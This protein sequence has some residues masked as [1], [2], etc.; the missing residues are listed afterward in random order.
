MAARTTGHRPLSP[1]IAALRERALSLQDSY[2]PG[3]RFR[4][5]TQF[6]QHEHDAADPPA[7]RQAKCFAYVLSS[8]DIAIHSLER[9]VGPQNRYIS[10]HMGVSEDRKLRWAQLLDAPEHFA[11]GVLPDGAPAELAPYCEFWRGKPTLWARAQDIWRRTS[12]DMTDYSPLFRASVTTRAH[13]ML[14]YREALDR[15]LNDIIDECD[16][17]LCCECQPGKRSFLGA[18]K[19][20]L[21]AGIQYS[22]RYANLA[23][24]MAANEADPE[25][26][27][28]LEAISANCGTCLEH[29]PTSFYQALQAVWLLHWLLDVETGNW[30]PADSLGRIDQYLY[31]FYE[32]DIS[33]GAMT[34]ADALELVEEF[35]VKR[36][37]IYE[38][39]HTMVGGLAPSGEPAVNDLTYLMLDAFERLDY[40]FAMGARV[41][42]GMDEG[43]L[44]RVADTMLL[45]RGL[46]IFN[47][48]VSVPAVASTGLTD[49][50]ARDYAVTG[51]VEYFVA[52]VHS[53]RTLAITINLLKC[54][55]L[56]LS[57]GVD[58]ASSTRLGRSAKAWGEYGSFDE[59][60]AAFFAEVEHA[61]GLAADKLAVFEQLDA[62]VWPLPFMSAFYPSCR[63]KATDLTAGGAK[64]TDAGV[65]PLAFATAV[66][67]LLAVKQAV[68]EERVVSADGL[69]DALEE[70]FAG[71]GPLRAYLLNRAPKYGNDDPSADALAGHVMRHF[72]D[73]LSSRRNHWGGRFTLICLTTTS[74]T[75]YD[76]NVTGRASPDG[77]LAGSPVSLNITPSPGA[78]REGISG[79]IQ[80]ALAI[81]HRLMTNGCSFVVECHPSHFR[82]SKGREAMRDLIR[83]FVRGG[84]MNL[85][86][87]LADAET[88]ARAKAAPER[89]RSLTVRIFGYSDYF[90][91]LSD[92]LKDALIEK[93]QEGKV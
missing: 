45:G 66:D 70:N 7:L 88:L 93:A 51:C 79:A 36:I 14:N 33:S 5:V 31:G 24:D 65:A 22:K 74:A 69:R 18:A 82:G 2:A 23:A 83:T 59:L 85:A 20:A 42:T 71:R 48:D 76:N 29:K 21:G 6:Y 67:S 9:I 87:N 25:R 78:I 47:D 60:L 38:D 40:P 64:T 86:V 91:N 19:I 10:V 52:G 56:A 17:R 72:Y 44:S 62:E 46:S 16:E 77:R 92:P 12:G 27:R 49:A 81:D 13:T 35:F 61:F 53:P 8:C 54:V 34:R 41:F 26:K 80:S 15:G 39:Q 28:E 1:R 58:P 75:V 89:Y 50:E 63:A 73:T 3:E 90:N 4:L 11:P 57:R 32:R 68:F 84:G 30:Q 43:Y 37:R 55:E